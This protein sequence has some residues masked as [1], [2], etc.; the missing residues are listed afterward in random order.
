MELTVR[1]QTLEELVMLIFRDQQS[2]EFLV[3]L[4]KGLLMSAE[5]HRT[6]LLAGE[7]RVSSE[8]IEAMA[9]IIQRASQVS[10]LENPLGSA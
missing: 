2:Q 3:Q 9:E 5:R 10:E 6:P 7:Y 1:I 8:V 4:H